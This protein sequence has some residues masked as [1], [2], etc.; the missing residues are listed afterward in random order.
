MMRPLCG[1][2]STTERQLFR[3]WSETVVVSKKELIMI[4][5]YCCRCTERHVVQVRTVNSCGECINSN[6]IFFRKSK[7][8]SQLSCLS[9]GIV[10]LYL[11]ILRRTLV[12]LNALGWATS[13][14][15]TH[16]QTLSLKIHTQLSVDSVT[17]CKATWRTVASCEQWQRVRREEVDF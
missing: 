8:R 2:W 17:E 6:Q 9:Y 15:N 13:P 16:T 3:S 10:K 12:T 5:P 1:N 7:L 4:M 14:Y 11:A